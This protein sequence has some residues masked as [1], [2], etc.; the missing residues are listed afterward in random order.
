MDMLLLLVMTAASYYYYEKTKDPNWK[1]FLRDIPALG[2]I[3]EGVGKS[4]EE[5]KPVHYAMGASG[6]QLYSRLFSMT[7][8]A[9]AF[10]R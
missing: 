3:T 4:V 7:R 2:A 6:G 9:R 1:P 5:N 10:L 8:G